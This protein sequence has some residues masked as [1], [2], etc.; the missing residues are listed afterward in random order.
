M[1]KISLLS[2]LL[3]PSITWGQAVNQLPTRRVSAPQMLT[4]KQLEQAVARSTN[5]RVF[6]L[7][8]TSDVYHHLRDTAT[9]NYIARL[10]PGDIIVVRT[11]YPHWLVIRRAQSPIQFSTD[12]TTYYIRRQAIKGSKMSLML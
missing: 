3:L 6:E 9:N 10:H 12:T 8:T 5:L 11:F 4:S 7:I 1:K 2:T